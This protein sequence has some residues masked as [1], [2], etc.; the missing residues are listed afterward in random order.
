[1][2]QAIKEITIP[3]LRQEGFKGSYPHF[4]R[5]TDDRINLLTF[6]F[7]MSASR[8]VVEIANCPLTG[9]TMSWGLHVP[10]AKCTAHDMFERH[11]LGR[12]N[13]SRD[14]WFVFDQTQPTNIYEARA[15]EIISLW[16]EAQKW[17]Q[18]NP[19]Q[20]RIIPA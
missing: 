4:R 1:M 6:Q 2:D 3:F 16:D 12:I 19:Y 5:V 15:K 18:D 14:Y 8:F 17:W 10:P 20:Q 7:S 13:H 9:I 11:R